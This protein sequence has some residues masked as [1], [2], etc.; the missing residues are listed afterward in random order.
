VL[1]HSP[2]ALAQVVE[3]VSPDASRSAINDAI[4]AVEKVKSECWLNGETIIEDKWLDKA[5]KALTSL[6]IEHQAK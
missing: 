6:Q 5:L 3:L 1:I 4:K 2:V